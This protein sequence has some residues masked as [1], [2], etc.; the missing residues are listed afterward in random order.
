MSSRKDVLLPYQI[1]NQDT[2]QS[3]L[4][5]EVINIQYLDNVSAQ[6][7]W[8]GNGTGTFSIQ[9]SLNYNARLPLT[10]IWD[11]ITLNPIPTVAGVSDTAL[12]DMNQ[13]SF[14]WIKLSFISTF[15]S[16][17]ITTVADSAGSLNNTY[18]QI[19]AGG[20]NKFAVWFN[21]NGA[22]TPPVVPGYTDVAIALATNAS[23]NTVASAINTALSS[24]TGIE[25]NTVLANVIT[26]NIISTTNSV[27]AATSGMTITNTNTTGLVDG[28]ISAKMI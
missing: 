1:F 27:S 13:L 24:L 14:P 12:L 15:L 25:R 10:A 7:S 5:S 16:G 19:N 2:L 26:F 18:L 22:G 28:F 21:V 20:T 17:S 3:D 6:L 11:T 4:E 23:A 9:G 8:T